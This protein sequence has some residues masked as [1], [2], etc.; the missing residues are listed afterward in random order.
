LLSWREPAKTFCAICFA[1]ILHEFILL[2]FNTLQQ[3]W[4]LPGF[5]LRSYNWQQIASRH[6]KLYCKDYGSGPR[7]LPVT[8][9]K[10]AALQSFY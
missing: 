10:I 6:C 5:K 1:K 4:V 3:K 7:Y 9:T 2:G 8:C